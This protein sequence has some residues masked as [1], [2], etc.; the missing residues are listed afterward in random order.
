MRMPGWIQSLLAHLY[1]LFMN[2]LYL[3]QVYLLL[4][5]GLMRMASLLQKY[6]PGGSS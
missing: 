2:R 4:G 5:R 3:D 1:V 6:A